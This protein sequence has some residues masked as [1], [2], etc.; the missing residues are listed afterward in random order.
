MLKRWYN[1]GTNGT[2][3]LFPLEGNFHTEQNSATALN[4]VPSYSLCILL[5]VMS[6]ISSLC[7]DLI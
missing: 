1:G 5:N 3:V 6:F 7:S 4:L 2:M